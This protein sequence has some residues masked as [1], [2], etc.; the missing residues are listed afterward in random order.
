MSKYREKIS[1]ESDL[2]AELGTG[3]FAETDDDGRSHDV[4]HQNGMPIPSVKKTNLFI[5][6][7]LCSIG[8]LGIVGLRT[9]IVQIVLGNADPYPG[10]G[11]VEWIGHALSLVPLIIGFIIIGVWG[12]KND[13]IYRQ[14]EAMKS[15]ATDSNQPEDDTSGIIEESNVVFVDPILEGNPY[16]DSPTPEDGSQDGYVSEDGPE[17]T[18]SEIKNELLDELRID[19]CNNVLMDAPLLP[20]DAEILRNLIRTG[21]SVQEFKG[22]VDDCVD[23]WKLTV[24]SETNVI[25]LNGENELISELAE[26]ER[27]EKYFLESELLPDDRRRIQSLMASGI[28]AEELE[29]EIDRAVKIRKMKEKAKKLSADEKASLLE[30]AL[31]ADLAELEDEIQEDSGD[32]LEYR[33]LKE[34]EDL[35]NL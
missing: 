10:L 35:E 9:G 16:R 27:L 28:P 1:Q 15:Q 33:I 17:F 7:V 26:L 18:S 4:G 23:K 31:I 24:E 21:I 22:K 30:D 13:P 19:E 25:E 3:Q 14:I 8:T 12:V 20:E 29:A 11:T 32:D 2:P 34:I 5:G 6:I